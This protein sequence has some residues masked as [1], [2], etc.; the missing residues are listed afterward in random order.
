MTDIP[1][2]L[3]V[4]AATLRTA[5]DWLP[6]DHREMLRETA[7]GVESCTDSYSLSFCCPVC[8][9]VHCDE[10]CPLEHVRKALRP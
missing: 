7:Q 5:A 10:G 1:P 6:D 8:Q 2:E 3:A 9:E 4:I